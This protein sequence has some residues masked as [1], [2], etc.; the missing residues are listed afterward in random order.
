M[1]RW[2]VTSD[3]DNLVCRTCKGVLRTHDDGTYDHLFSHNDY[4][5][6][7]PVMERIVTK[8]SYRPV[9]K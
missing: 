2:K 4:H 7:V 1:P 5:K 9:P 8:V 3:N 6:V